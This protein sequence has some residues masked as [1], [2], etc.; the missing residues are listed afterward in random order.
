MKKNDEIRALKAEAEKLKTVA[1][2][3]AIPAG[4][5][6]AR[7]PDDSGSILQ[8]KQSLKKEIE[9]LRKQVIREQGIA[10]DARQDALRE[11]LITDDAVKASEEARVELKQALVL[12]TK[13][14]TS[15]SQ[16]K[17]ACKHHLEA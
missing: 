6:R 13:N 16:V 10:D 4:A 15:A 11:K 9:A 12:A 1:A 5:K 2:A 8:T 7:N 3:A 17:A 14:N